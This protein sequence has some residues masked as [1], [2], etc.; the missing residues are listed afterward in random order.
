MAYQPS[1]LS[2]L[3]TNILNDIRLVNGLFAYF[4]MTMFAL[5]AAKLVAMLLDFTGASAIKIERFGARKGYWAVVTG[6]T[7][8]IGKELTKQL[9]KKKFNL[10]LISR[11]QQKLEDFAKEIEAEYGV[12]T[13]I[14]VVDFTKITQKNYDEIKQVLDSIPVGV[15]ANNVGLSH[16]HSTPF[17]EEDMER[18]RNMIHI[19]INGLVEMTRIVL[20]QMKERKNGLILN[21]GSYA[22]LIPTPFLSVYSGTK[23]FVKNFSQALAA[24]VEKDGIVVQHLT[25]YFVATAMTKVRRATF[26]I[27]T[28]ESYAKNI[29]RYLGSPCGTNSPYTMVPHFG[30]AIYVFFTQN[31]LSE[32][33]VVKK[34]YDHGLVFYKRWLKKVA[35]ENEKAKA[36]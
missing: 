5:Y 20:P 30:H 9:A 13:K 10:V 15:L 25:T 23:A 24:E 8:G 17:L 3:N 29:I 22:G 1:L 32:S 2:N 35:R 18:V 14:Y 11:S 19:N 6:C 34:S 21:S 26:L 16:D 27:P 12:E 4:G 33:F 36:N 28:A 7:D 31:I